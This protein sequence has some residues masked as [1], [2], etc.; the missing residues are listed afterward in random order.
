[1]NRLKSL[2]LFI[3]FYSL[4]SNSQIEEIVKVRSKSSKTAMEN[5]ANLVRLRDSLAIAE[6]TEQIQQLS[7]NEIHI[8]EQ[9]LVYE[10]RKAADSLAVHQRKREIDSLRNVIEGKPVVIS[11]DTLFS[12]FPISGVSSPIT[13][14]GNT[15]DMI[16]QL[17]KDPNVIP[18]SIN[19][20]VSN[21]YIEI[22]YGNREIIILS[23]DD[24]LWMNMPLETLAKEYRAKIV[25]KVKHL[26]NEN[27][28]TN[29]FKRSL[30]FAGVL[31]ALG[32]FIYGL[33][34]LFKK[35]KIRMKSHIKTD[36]VEFFSHTYRFLNIQQ[37]FKIIFLAMK[38]LQYMLILLS[39]VVTIPMLFFIFPRTR[40]I[41]DTLFGYI[42]TPIKSICTSII[43]YI[44]NLFTIVIICLLISYILKGLNYV[45]KEIASEKL[46]IP[47]FF[48]D[49]A[50]PTF[51]LMRFILYAFMVA[52]I[53]PYLPGSDSGIFQG[54]SVFVGVMISLGSTAVIG[55]IVAGLVII[56]MRPF[57]I[58]DMIKLND[59]VGKVI[60]KTAFSTRICTLKNEII[61]IPN[62]FVLSSHT[63][64]YTA[65]AENY[66][67]I[68]HTSIGVGY[69]IP[70]ARVHELLIKAARITEGVL[71]DREPFVLD[72]KI[73]AL[74]QLYEINVYIN[75]ANST[76]KISSDLHRNIQIIFLE[77][78]IELRTA[79]Q[80][81]RARRII[82]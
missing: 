78:G 72:K 67:L 80:G 54:V 30:E 3:V 20:T 47:G 69:E 82:D 62:S 42:L 7:Q 24:A 28:K 16:Y 2:F 41:A 50:L 38:A 60:E 9:L 34:Y 55:N 10:K 5:Q 49:W 77:A 37:T 51:N 14:A 29:L 79:I 45:S 75:D 19:L 27:S 32:V 8:Q 36:S 58:G 12:I 53:Y 4:P 61:T 40:A 46:R 21:G 66:G 11:E 57:R 81:E 71:S 17:S 39:F 59:T 74:Y 31:I 22:M 70:N 44:P 1:M 18:D 52:M 43:L 26:Q 33:N 65:S 15:A 23:E 13:R 25:E 64:N 76:G 73:E 35:L 48:P 6:L 63:T 68:I 56:Y